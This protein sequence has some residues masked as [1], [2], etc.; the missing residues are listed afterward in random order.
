MTKIVEDI[1][2]KAKRLK[3]TIVL[4]EADEPRTIKAAKII[5]KQGIA[6]VVLLGAQDIE[7]G[8]L[9]QFSTVFYELRKHKGISL[10]EARE[11][12][13]RPLYYAAMLVRQGLADGFVAGASHTTPDVARAAIYCLGVDSRFITASS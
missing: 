12:I 5:N 2:Q 9:E 11:T 8:K 6:K 13:N 4:P 7:P 10:E 3:K 1:R